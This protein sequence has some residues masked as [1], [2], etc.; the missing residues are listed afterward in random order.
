MNLP[1]LG[2]GFVHLPGLENL[3][4]AISRSLDVVEV[5]AQTFWS[6]DPA[7]DGAEG[8]RVN[9]AGLERASATG[10]ATLVHSV[11]YP[12]GGSRDADPRHRAALRET[13]ALLKPL[14]WSEH[15]SFLA[16]Y[17]EAGPRH[18]GFLMPPVQTKA[19]VATIAD[20]IR[21]LQDDFGLPFAF[22]T[23]V[24]YLRPLEGELSDG[25]FWG[26]I[27]E[28]A[29]CG[30]LLDIHNV[31]T[32]QVNGRQ[33]LAAVAD[34]LPLER[35]WEVHVAG[36]QWHKDYWLDSHS[37]LP[38]DEVLRAAAALV[39]RLPALH[40]ITLEII[41][42]QIEA[43]EISEGQLEACLAA[44]RAI[45]ETRGT[46]AAGTGIAPGVTG[47]DDAGLPSMEAWEL[48][49]EV[50]VA[51]G[52]A[53][54]APFAGD[55]GL[56]IYRDLIAA[57]RRGT[58]VDALPLSTRYLYRAL[59][60]DG[61]KALLPAFWREARPEP[62]MSDEARNFAA[63]A[64]A[65]VA[66][67]HLGELLDF[68]LAAHRAAMSGQAQRVGFT[69]DPQPLLTALASGGALRIEPATVEVEVTPPA[70][71]DAAA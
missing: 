27:A 6:H 44:L 14:W 54:R 3:T 42:E 31:W 12:I 2:I 39:P 37:G 33:P 65:K 59:G 29:D 46:A 56:E 47:T 66:L 23:G 60:E 48:L 18:V 67:P 11:G 16:A 34:L 43:R 70:R 64:R 22:E 9:R 35:I 28:S 49:L 20:R 7:S 24:S 53:V 1:D 68:E 55:P 51:S 36:G 63:F 61:L 41:A 52:E 30:I 69:C 4:A 19:S 25:D 40:A 62:F 50:A 21:R 13:F 26:A 45:W 58:L 57:A 71:L 17:G 15:A 38:P 8:F 32:N 5:E 10:L